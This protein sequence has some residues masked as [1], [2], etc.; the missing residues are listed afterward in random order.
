MNNPSVILLFGAGASYGAGGINNTP[1]LAKDLF[2]ELYNRYPET[3]GKITTK[4]KRKFQNE[5]K[6]TQDFEKCMEWLY[7]SKGQTN[8]NLNKLLRDFSVYFDSF[9]IDN[10]E[11]NY[12]Y[13]L[14]SNFKHEIVSNKII[15][16]T[17]NYDCLI[18]YAYMESGINT[19]TYRGFDNNPRILKL[20]GSCNFIPQNVTGSLNGLTINLEKSKIETNFEPCQPGKVAYNLENVPIPPAMSLFLKGK[21]DIVCTKMIK[22]I[23]EQY[24]DIVQ[25]ASIVISIGVRPNKNDYHVWDS[26]RSVAKLFLVGGK[27][28][29]K[30]KQKNSNSE[31]LGSTFKDAYTKIENIIKSNI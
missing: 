27:D 10:F 8:H 22:E 7:S 28:C 9:R 15:C 6:Q 24:K 31:Y 4:E 14:I 3:W 16:V 23:R 5:F 29:K 1:P 12:Y 20:H 2:D 21:T 11:E 19:I 25:S 17:I 26:L 18:E 13:K 30:W